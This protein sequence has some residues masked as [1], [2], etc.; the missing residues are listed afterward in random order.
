MA[1]HA[2]SG[3]RQIARSGRLSRRGG[4]L[5]AGVGIAFAGLPLAMKH[6]MRYAAA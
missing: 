5:A 1:P 6:R 2:I 4:V 3:A